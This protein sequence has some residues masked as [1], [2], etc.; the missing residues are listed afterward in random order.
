[1]RKSFEKIAKKQKRRAFALLSWTGGQ[2][3]CRYVSWLGA[4]MYSAKLG[5][6]IYGAKLAAM[7]TPR[8]RRC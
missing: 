5:A 4:K 8:L 7:S 3:V 1:L 6:K 2:C